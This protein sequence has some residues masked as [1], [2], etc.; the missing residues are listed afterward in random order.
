MLALGALLVTAPLGIITVAQSGHGAADQRV[1]DLATATPESVG[2]SSERLRRIDAAMKRAVDDKQTAGV[3]TLLER[4]GKV[5]HFNAVGQK[6]VRKPDPVQKDSIFRIYSMTKPVTGVAM[7][8]LYEEG[9]WRL[10]DPV[11]S[12]EGS[13]TEARHSA[14][15]AKLR[16]WTEAVRT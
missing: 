7:M 16:Y 13:L 5:I 4:H 2:V 3:V 9:K 10:E 8:M 12:N 15:E 11:S 1:R 14:V 6:D